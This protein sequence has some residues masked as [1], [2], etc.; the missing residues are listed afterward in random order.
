MKAKKLLNLTVVLLALVMVCNT[1]L[2]D[3]PFGF[4]INTSPTEYD[5][6]S[7]V[8]KN[9]YICSTAPKPHN[10]FDAY[11][12]WHIEGIGVCALIATGKNIERDSY[13]V[14]IKRRVDDVKGQIEKKYGPP[15]DQFNF[16]NAGSIWDEPNDWMMG[17]YQ[18][19]RRY[20]YYWSKNLGFKP[21]GTVEFILLE[22]IGLSRSTGSINL[23][24]EYKSMGSCKTE[25]SNAN[26]DIF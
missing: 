26:S 20:I 7:T 3:D 4:A 21:V 2:A 1:T 8:E 11:I 5:F 15:S 23:K 6:C 9:K 13:G 25:E 22:A 16:L 19:E 14:E 10:E 24:F 18:N 17:L 12:L